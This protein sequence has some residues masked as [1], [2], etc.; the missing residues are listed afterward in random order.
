MHYNPDLFPEPSKFRPERFLPPNIIP[1]DAWR[2]FEKGPRGCMGV[3]LA[4]MEMR[5]TLLLVLRSL[6][7]KVVGLKPY[8]NPF[9][10]YTNM[11]E[12]YGDMA[13]QNWGTAAKP[14]D[15]MLMR[16]KFAA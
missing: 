3:D 5:I 9:A 11:D 12:V 10:L 2:P 1:K 16:V 8:T 4:M 6:D 13:F 7:F 14:R 15:G